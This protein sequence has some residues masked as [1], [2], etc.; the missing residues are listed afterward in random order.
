MKAGKNLNNAA[1]YGEI[2]NAAAYGESCDGI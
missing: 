2:N 1:A